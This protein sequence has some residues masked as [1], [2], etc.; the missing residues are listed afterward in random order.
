MPDGVISTFT[1]TGNYQS[2]TKRPWFSRNTQMREAND[3][4]LEMAIQWPF[5]K[6]IEIAWL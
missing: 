1:N 6:R 4:F 2:Q 5:S 3:S